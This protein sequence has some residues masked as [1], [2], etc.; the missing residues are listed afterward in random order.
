M[1]QVVPE[2]SSAAGN[3]VEEKVEKGKGAEVLAGA[4]AGVVGAA[5]GAGI[6]HHL[7]DKQVSR[8]RCTCQSLKLTLRPTLTLPK[9]KSDRAVNPIGSN[10]ESQQAGYF[11]LPP[12]PHVASFVGVTPQPEQVAPHAA[13]NLDD[14]PQQATVQPGLTDNTFKQ[15][16]QHLSTAQALPAETFQQDMAHL[17]APIAVGAGVGAGAGAGVLASRELGHSVETQEGAVKQSEIPPTSLDAKAHHGRD[18]ALVG[19]AAALGGAGVAKAA[20]TRQDRGTA[21]SP[22]P[23]H[24]PAAQEDPQSASPVRASSVR[25]PNKL[26]KAR[27]IDAR[28]QGRSSSPQL[29]AHPNP[30]YSAE[31]GAQ[32]VQPESVSPAH[33]AVEEGV[34]YSP[35][36]KI[37]TRRDSVGHRKLHKSSPSKD[38]LAAEYHQGEGSP[39]H[40]ERSAGEGVWKGSVAH[41]SLA[42][43]LSSDCKTDACGSLGCQQ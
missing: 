15:D 11:V 39:S 4:G 30:R 8:A 28:D 7:E 6:I 24:M 35:H 26:H 40:A 17:S 41:V 43:S 27:S 29:Q 42:H 32:A 37:A 5:A 34:Q 33:S 16:M 22:S 25:V 9:D 14:P 21:T 10:A 1:T 31:Y 19:G 2:K 12:I 23:A 36:M 20:S 38:G 18:A 3:E 13:L